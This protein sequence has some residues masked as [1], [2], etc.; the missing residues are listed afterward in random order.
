MVSFVILVF[1][2]MF[3][4][5][6]TAQAVMLA[7]SISQQF[8]KVVF[9][10]LLTFY[11]VV[12]A[13][14]TFLFVRLPK[15]LYVP[16]DESSPE[17]QKYLEKLGRRLERNSN[18]KGRTAQL[19]TREEIQVAMK[20]LDDQCSGIIRAK[21]SAVFLTTA[22]SQNGRLD[23]FSVLAAQTRMVWEI[24]HLYNQRPT[25][26]EMSQL[27]ANVGAAV[28]LASELQNIDI[29]EQIE[30][31]IRAV[32]G[33]TLLA[34]IPGV[35]ALSS[36]VVQSLLTGTS[37]AYLTLR[38]GIVCQRYCGSISRSNRKWIIGS[39]S[40]SAAGMLGS[41]V[42][43]SG[44]KLVQSVVAIAKNVGVSAV[45]SAAGRVREVGSKLNPFG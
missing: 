2:V 36:L 14:P 30:P 8:G 15:L 44:A 33:T 38:V 17:F 1:V 35:T 21:A 9:Y 18:L 24:A 5:T 13:V 34:S 41:I 3:V 7:N 25:L 40:A 42:T 37:N 31:T 39:A 6:Q 20:L 4:F 32:I 11:A 43:S 29:S 45:E 26:R 22:I 28:F 16:E 27:Y 19:R 12:V 10:A 23:A